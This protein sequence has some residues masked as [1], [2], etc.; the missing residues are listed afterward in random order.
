MKTG[1]GFTLVE[2][3]IVVAIVAILASIAYPA[4]TD[5]VRKSRRAEAKQALMERAQQLERCYTR[6]GSYNN[7]G[8][9]EAAAA[10]YPYDSVPNEFYSITAA[11]TATTFTLTAT[12]QGVQAADADCATFNLTHTSARTATNAN[13]W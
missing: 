6:F 1:K 7:A 8:C 9:A 2:V 4:Y 10:A 11:I 3:M 12:A 5:H 13:C